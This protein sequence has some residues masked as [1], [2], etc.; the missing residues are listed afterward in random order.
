MVYVMLA[1]GFEEV[2]AISP[3]DVLRRGGVE[4]KTVG[5]TG[6][7]V[8]G[9]HGVPVVADCTPDEVVLETADMVIL[10]G[11]MPGTKNLYASDFVRNAVQY[12]VDYDKYIAAICA[13]PSVILGGMGLLKGKEATCYPGMEDG[14]IGAKPQDKP[15][16]VDGKII[17]GRAAGTALD[18]ALALCAILKGQD[19]ADQ[20]RRDIVYVG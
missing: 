19:V 16:C 13:A 8:A 11:G 6:K 3:I 5:V 9:A 4:L 14:M 1:E 18:F 7:T 17:T 12:C 2:E 20:V 15:F 10:P